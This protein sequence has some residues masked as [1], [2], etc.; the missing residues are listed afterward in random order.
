MLVWVGLL[1]DELPQRSALGVTGQQVRDR[2]PDPVTRRG[3]A[4]VAG[5]HHRRGGHRSPAEV[6]GHRSQRLAASRRVLGPAWEWRRLAD[7]GDCPPVVALCPGPNEQPLAAVDRAG[8][9]RERP[10]EFERELPCVDGDHLHSDHRP[11]GEQCGVGGEQATCL[12]QRGVE[13]VTAGLREYGASDEGG[14]RGGHERGE[15]GHAET[16]VDPQHHRDG[17]RRQQTEQVLRAARTVAETDGE[18]PL[19]SLAVGLEVANIV[20]D[21][22][23]C[24]QRRHRQ[25]ADDDRLRHRPGGTVVV[26]GSASTWTA[27]T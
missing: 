25:G 6:V 14:V 4:V 16:T 23:S 9:G 26:S 1:A 3:C 17:V 15:N 2:E 7:P 13:R 18:G 22:D 19:A 8:G 11:G 10:P 20:D 12:L 24:R 5:G 27:W 21:E